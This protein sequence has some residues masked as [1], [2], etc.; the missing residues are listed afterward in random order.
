VVSRKGKWGV[1][2]ARDV[3][4]NPAYQ[5]ILLDGEDTPFFYQQRL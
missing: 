5:P 4:A 3:T 2:L 1:A